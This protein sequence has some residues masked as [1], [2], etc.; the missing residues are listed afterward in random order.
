MK[1]NGKYFAALIIKGG[2]TYI[3]LSHHVLNLVRPCPGDDP[4][5]S[6]ARLQDETNRVKEAK[7]GNDI[8]D[9]S[10]ANWVDVEQEKS[11]TAEKEGERG[12]GE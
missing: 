4:W 1:W 8:E 7:E 10:N 12:V 5:I 3:P 6:A 9:H 2:L 11:S